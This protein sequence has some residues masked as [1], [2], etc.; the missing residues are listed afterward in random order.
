MIGI[1]VVSH[2]SRLAEGVVEL[3]REMGGAEVA[4]EAAGGLGPPA[5]S[6][7]PGSRR[8]ELAERTAPS[9]APGSRRPELAERTAPSE[10]P[11]SRRP[12]V[13]ERTGGAA[14]G[15]SAT[16]VLAAIERAWSDD[17][18]L[19]LMDLGSAVLSAETA[20]DLLGPERRERGLL[21]AAPPVRGA[22]AAAARARGGRAP[23]AAAPRGG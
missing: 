12:E 13:A 19:V 15:T 21:C 16:E 18:V 11:G 23:P 8:P 1:V 2:S 22:G 3:A 4:V 9:E 10:A 5:P 7:A 14:L 6:E 20:L 17:G